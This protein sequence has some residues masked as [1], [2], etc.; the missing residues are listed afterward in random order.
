MA[1]LGD[2]EILYAALAS[3]I[4]VV[5]ATSDFKI[6]QQRLYKARRDSG[7]PELS[8]LQFRSSPHHPDEIWVVKGP[9]QG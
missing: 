2:L 7:D 8:V 9:A 4:G 1:N 5:V 3:P 6:A